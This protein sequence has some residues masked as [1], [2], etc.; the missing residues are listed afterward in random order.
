MDN[1]GESLDDYQQDYTTR[2]KV[3]IIHVYAT[4]F[5]LNYVELGTEPVDKFSVQ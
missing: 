1:G 4:L 3:F 2:K 5:C